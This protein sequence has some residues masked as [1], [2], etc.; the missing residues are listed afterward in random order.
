MPTIELTAKSLD[1]GRKLAAAKLNVAPETVEL[2][3]LEETKGL[4]GRA[5][6]KLSAT[7]PEAPAPE[8]ARPTKFAPTEESAVEAPIADKPKTTR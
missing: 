3:V 7:A 6:L 4:F 5:V 8:T 1:E 2:T